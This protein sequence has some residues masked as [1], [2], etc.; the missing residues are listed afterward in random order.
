M[1]E[2]ALA[3]VSYAEYSAREAES[4]VRH[5]FHDGA[6]IAMAGGTPEHSLLA[7]RVL[8]ALG[9]AL[10]H[11]PYTLFESNLRIYVAP[12]RRALYPD[13]SIV[14]GKL[15]RAEQDRD[16]VVNPRVIVEVLSPTTEAYDRGEK[17]ELYQA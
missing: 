7:A 12:S 2:R 3:R 10:S 5:E 9:R 8:V 11:G 14:C 1:A 15:V 4:S 13:A 6:V 17:F 16:A